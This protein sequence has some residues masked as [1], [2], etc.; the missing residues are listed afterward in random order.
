MPF[1]LRI[2]APED[3][4]DSEFDVLRRAIYVTGPTASGKTAVGI[5]LA[6]R[7]NAEIVSLD[8][9]AVYRGM[10]I[11]TAKPTITE[12]HAVRHHLLDVLEPWEAATV[13]WYRQAA[14]CVVRQILARGKQPLFVG[15]TALYLKAL[16]RGLFRGPEADV[17]IRARLEREA[18]AELHDRLTRIDP[19]TAARLHPN[20][21][22]RVIRA[23]EVAELTGRPISAWHTEHGRPAAGFRVFALARRREEL[24]ARIE[25]RIHEMFAMGFVEEVRRLSTRS[26]PLHR[27][28]AQAVGYREI[29]EHLEGKLTLEQAREQMLART[30]RFARHQE[31]WFRNL[32]EVERVAVG[33]DDS[34]PAIAN[35]LAERL[36]AGTA[37]HREF[38]RP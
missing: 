18:D 34:A 16:L 14:L 24:H 12:R 32:A 4:P 26:R 25:R 3:P 38:T 19:A 6:E 37:L 31:T 22:R 28:P 7:L 10:D 11:G 30:R 9:M 15:G 17:E 21:R 35:D 33:R 27:T 5:A 29:L 13:A 8:S 2:S 1:E 20:D 36:G 23:L